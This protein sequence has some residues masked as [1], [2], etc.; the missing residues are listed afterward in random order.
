MLINQYYKMKSYQD[1]PSYKHGFSLLEVSISLTVISLIIA[2]V[3]TGQNIKHRLELNQVITDISTITSAVKQFKD[4][5]SNSIPGDFASAT[6]S[7]GSTTSDGNGD[8]DL[9]TGTPNEELLFW[10]HLQLAGLISGTYDGTTSGKGGLMPTQQKYGFYFAHKPTG[11]RLNIQVS[12]VGDYGL[13]STLEAEAFDTK[14]DDGNPGFTNPVTTS[15]TIKG[16]DGTGD[17]GS[18]FTVNTAPTPDN[19]NTTNLTGTPCVLYFYL[20]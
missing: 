3:L 13:F 8:N 6:N 1:K 4:V 17:S 2:A 18:C 11:G 19:Y 20:E 16:V 7:L 5:Y 14:Y 15:S 10:Q 12:K 9:D